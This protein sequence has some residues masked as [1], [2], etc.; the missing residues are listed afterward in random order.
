MQTLPPIF[1]EGCGWPNF[2][3]LL[4]FALQHYHFS[5]VSSIFRYSHISHEGEFPRFSFQLI[6]L[7]SR[8]LWVISSASSPWNVAISGFPA[9][10]AFVAGHGCVTSGLVF[11]AHAL[12]E[13]RDPWWGNITCKDMGV[14]IVM[15]IPQNGWSIMENTIKHIKMI[16]QC[17]WTLYHG[18]YHLEMDVDWGVPWFQE[19]S[20]WPDHQA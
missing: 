7:Y 12:E 11:E 6:Q 18:K 10:Q 4:Q 8:D 19:T 15:G 3:G 16:P 9:P 17:S 14:S 5:W 2:A 1:G 13:L 20:K